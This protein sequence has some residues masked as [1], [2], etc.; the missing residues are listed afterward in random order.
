M[1]GPFLVLYLTALVYSRPTENE[2]S[3]GGKQRVAAPSAAGIPYVTARTVTARTHRRKP[4]PLD[5]NAATTSA[6]LLQL[7]EHVEFRCSKCRRDKIRDDALAVDEAAGIVMC[8]RCFSRIIKPKGFRP[9]R[10]I[11]FPSLLS[12]LNHKGPDVR[13]EVDNDV[14]KRS[15]TAALPSGHRVAVQA[16]TAPNATCLPITPM[17]IIG[18]GDFDWSAKVENHYTAVADAAAATHAATVARA[19]EVG[20]HPCL[21]VFGVCPHGA[22]CFFAKAP[23]NLSLTWL[24]GLPALD[25]AEVKE[26]IFDLPCIDARPPRG[27]EAAFE[28]WVEARRR[29]KNQA[30][31]QMWNNPAVDSLLDR[32][33]PKPQEKPLV[34]AL[35]TSN[36]K[37]LLGSL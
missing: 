21:R 27:D 35:T 25:S 1:C 33:V 36:L 17:N 11:P 30:E 37:D 10:M 2:M 9:T 24:M 13:T 5:A 6:R 22:L 29:S 34:S 19:V 14:T 28:A 15:A 4:L 16:I 8:V 23:I 18:G 32:L 20:T 31:W 26:P 3:A 12:W 7:D